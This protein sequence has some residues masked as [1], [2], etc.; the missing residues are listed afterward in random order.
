MNLLQPATDIAAGA[1]KVAIFG[2]GG[3][4]KTLTS[5]LLA[6]G[7]SKTHHDGRAIVFVDPEGVSE[8]IAPICAAEGVPLFVVPTRTFVEMREALAEAEDAD[9]CVFVVDHYD[10]IFRELTEAQKLKLNLVGHQLPYAHREELVRLWDEWVR[11]FR[12]SSLDCVF[13]GRLAWDWGDDEDAAGDPLKVKLGTKMRGES[14]AGYEPNLLIELERLD[15]F[16]RDKITKRKNGQIAHVA[17]VLKD[18]RMVLNGLSFSWKDLNAYKAGDYQRV[19]HDLASH[20]LP[21]GRRGDHSESR[22]VLGGRSSAELFAPV[23]GDS[24]FTMRARRVTIAAEEIQ[25]ALATIWPGQTT[26]EKRLRHIVLETLFQS[27]SWTAIETRAPEV[28]EAG[29]RIMQHFEAACA[30]INVKDEAEVIACIQSCK[31]LELETAKAM[32]L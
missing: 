23:S 21:V 11:T 25:A 10:T 31:D 14:D 7:L 9:A 28:V 1:G 3:S 15:Q 30:D 2:G 20:F 27:R 6:I 12:A 17:R 24:A 32:V 18:R 13:T 4:G 19:W 5:I 8:F 26:E 29:W 22:H 16:T